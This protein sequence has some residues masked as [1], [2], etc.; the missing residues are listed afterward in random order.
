MNEYKSR[1]DYMGFTPE[2]A[3][4]LEKL[5]PWAESIAKKFATKFY[6]PQFENAEFSA[7]V[8]N[9]GSIRSTLEGAQAGYM[10]GWFSG[11]PDEGYIKYRQLIGERHADIGVTPQWYISSYRLYE[12]IF[13]PMVT[14][15]LRLSRTSAKKVLGALSSLMAFD[16]AIIMDKYIQGLTDQIQETVDKVTVAAKSVA[17][18]SNEMS[19]TAEQAGSATQ[20]IASASQ[21]IASGATN[22]A[23]NVQVTTASMR[24]LTDAITKITQ[25]A[26]EQA[27][28]VDNANTIV[29]NVS[30]LADEVSANA[31][32]ALEEAQTAR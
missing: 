16:Q 27:S 24:E 4:T 26:Q 31:Q 23:E 2:D 1:L 7:I 12:T 29:G 28:A 6:D 17:E 18:S 19:N 9:Y 30:S 20:H 5:K 25:G 22:Q 11:Y 21:E 3:R 10:L 8:S 13:F 15:H 14:K 32:T